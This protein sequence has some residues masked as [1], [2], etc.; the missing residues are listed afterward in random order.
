MSDQQIIPT[1]ELGNTNRLRLTYS[2]F[3]QLSNRTKFRGPFQGVVLQLVPL[4]RNIFRLGTRRD[5]STAPFYK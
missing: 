2:E 3:G 4:T 1:I 5:I